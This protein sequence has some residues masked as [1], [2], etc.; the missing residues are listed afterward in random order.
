MELELRTSLWRTA[1]P[2]A[3]LQQPE[4]E[5]L[6][7]LKAF[8]FFLKLPKDFFAE[9][10]RKLESAAEERRLRVAQP[11][12]KPQAAHGSRNPSTRLIFAPFQDSKDE[13]KQKIQLLMIKTIK[14][15]LFPAE[16]PEF[17]FCNLLFCQQLQVL[18]CLYTARAE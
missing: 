5:L 9:S 2:A 15:N 14:M 7:L 18:G 17:K 8:S 3:S 1:R 16:T 6:G 10:L 11:T 13:N 12:P 4:R